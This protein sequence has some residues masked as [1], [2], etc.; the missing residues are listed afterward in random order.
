MKERQKKGTEEDA[1]YDFSA[2][3]SASPSV[4]GRQRSLGRWY[5]W[6]RA[7]NCLRNF[8]ELL[9]GR[10]VSITTEIFIIIIG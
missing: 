1:A 9:S 3:F 5:R 2:S 8:S 4:G 7:D 10:L 6:K